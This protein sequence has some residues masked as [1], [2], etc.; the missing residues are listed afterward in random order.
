LQLKSLY[1]KINK[2]NFYVGVLA[3][4]PTRATVGQTAAGVIADQF[5]RTRGTA[6]SPNFMFSLFKLYL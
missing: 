6:L 2:M 5:Q 4:D 1:G 3:E